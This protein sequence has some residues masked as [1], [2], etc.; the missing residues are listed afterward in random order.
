MNR[1]NDVENDD[2]E[3]I[4]DIDDYQQEQP[5]ATVFRFQKPTSIR[6]HL[7]CNKYKNNQVLYI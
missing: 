4:P 6:K 2:S 7:Q 5:G 1:R 3:E